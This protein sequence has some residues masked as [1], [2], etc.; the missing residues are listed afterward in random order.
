[1]M[2]RGRSGSAGRGSAGRAARAAACVIL[3]L[4]EATHVQQAPAQQPTVQQ[5]AAPTVRPVPIP[6]PHKPALPVSP[7]VPAPASSTAVTFPPV[8]VPPSPAQQLEATT[9]QIPAP[10]MAAK[11]PD[12]GKP[13]PGAA[14]PPQRITGDPGTKAVPPDPASDRRPG[15]VDFAPGSAAL[16]PAATPA[17][18][19]IAR[20]LAADPGLR[21]A[22][23][24]RAPGKTA[25]AARRLSLD[26]AFAIRDWLHQHG[27]DPV[28]VVVR[29][30]GPGTTGPTDRVDMF[31]IN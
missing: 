18:T 6:P 26:R 8:T 15:H 30:L 23:D 14:M 16:A 21:V 19:D 1:M 2:R 7:T 12:L 17:L 5:P 27:I 10:D 11:I 25:A 28:R 20:R 3:F 31:M 4:A 9:P 22:L 13:M 24:A 29:P